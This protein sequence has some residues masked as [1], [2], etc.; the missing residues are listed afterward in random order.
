MH[1]VRGHEIALETG[2]DPVR[3]R[4]CLDI[5]SEAGIITAADPQLHNRALIRSP[6]RLTVGDIVNTFRSKQYRLRLATEMGQKESKT[7]ENFL[8]VIRKASGR[9]DTSRPIESWT[10]REFL[11]K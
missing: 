5:L 11:G 9:L 6:E 4:N 2:S 8:E 10:I 3:V 1:E 7:E